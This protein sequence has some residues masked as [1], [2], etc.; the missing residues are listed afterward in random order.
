MSAANLTVAFVKPG[1]FMIDVAMSVVLDRDKLI[2]Q[3]SFLAGFEVT[4]R[5]ELGAHTLETIIDVGAFKRRRAYA[6]TLES[7]P[8]YRSSLPSYRI[9]LCY[10]RFWGN[11]TRKL[12]MQPVG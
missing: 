9:D 6:F 8:D 3:G 7:L 11:F 2:Y 1:W 12:S 10:S 4:G 5:V